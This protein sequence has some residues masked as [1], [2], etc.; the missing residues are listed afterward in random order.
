MD[1]SSSEMWIS[2][3]TEQIEKSQENVKEEKQ[4]MYKQE[5]K[6]NL[7]TFFLIF[8]FNDLDEKSIKNETSNLPKSLQKEMEKR[9]IGKNIFRN[10]LT[11]KKIHDDK[12]ITS[13]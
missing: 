1:S 4:G 9:Q 11:S 13:E 10:L 2:P 7:H 5:Q 3:D 12:K 6:V 8:Q